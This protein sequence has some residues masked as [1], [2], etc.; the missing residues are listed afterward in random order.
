MIQ[1]QVTEN[2]YLPSAKKIITGGVNPALRP[3]AILP[4]RN[5]T[6]SALEL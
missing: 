4:A 3:E 2:I 6:Q 5:I 1:L